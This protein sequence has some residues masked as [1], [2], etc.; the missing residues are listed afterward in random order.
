MQIRETILTRMNQYY[1]SIHIN[2]FSSFIKSDFRDDT[3]FDLSEERAQRNA[4]ESRALLEEISSWRRLNDLSWEE[5]IELDIVEDFCHYILRNSEY[6][7]YKFNL[8]HNTTPLPYVV[9]RLETFPL[10]QKKRFRF[11]HGTVGAVSRK[12][13]WNDKKTAWTGR[14]GNFVACGAARHLFAPDRK[15]LPG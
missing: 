4:L 11:L 12:A 3:L 2:D 5:E 6:F 13:C 9:K 15:S 7:W 14:K 1:H 8:T 10:K